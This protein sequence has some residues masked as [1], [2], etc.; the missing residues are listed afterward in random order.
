N[1]TTAMA[2]IRLPISNPLHYCKE[3]IWD[4]T[5]TQDRFFAWAD[6][7]LYDQVK[8]A[9][10]QKEFKQEVGFAA[11]HHGATDSYKQVQFGEANVQLTFH[12]NDTKVIDGLTCIKIEPDIDYFKDLLSH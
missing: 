8:L 5:M 9:A 12:A 2:S 4:S 7:A 3:L 11:F 1:L 10:H 6:P